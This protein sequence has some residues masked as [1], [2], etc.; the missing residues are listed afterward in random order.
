MTSPT[1]TFD[2]YLWPAGDCD[3]LLLKTPGGRWGLIDCGLSSLNPKLREQERVWA[4]VEDLK[5]FLAQHNIT[6]LAFVQL[7]HPELDHAK[8]LYQVLKDMEF[9]VFCTV[10]GALNRNSLTKLKELVEDRVAEGRTR[11]LG[12]ARGLSFWQEPEHRFELVALG[13]GQRDLTAFVVSL[14]RKL[15]GQSGGTTPVADPAKQVGPIIEDTEQ[16]A[17]P[18]SHPNES[19]KPSYN[20]LSII[21][22]AQY[23]EAR[24]LLGADALTFSWR[25]L[26]K[27]PNFAVP[28]SANQ[29]GLRA[30]VI[31]LPHHGATDGLPLELAPVFLQ[32]KAEALISS[33]G[34]GFSSP[35]SEVL[36]GFTIKGYQ[37][38]CTGRSAWCPELAVGRACTGLNLV[39]I[40]PDGR[41]TIASEKQGRLT[42]PGKCHYVTPA[43]VSVTKGQNSD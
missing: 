25:D 28:V 22:L 27:S 37:V 31:K 24:V 21:T 16:R 1:P 6:R 33:S 2:L 30:Q 7:S 4:M 8:G 13:P 42:H 14:Q 39:T 35:S 10:S 23:G 18:G 12:A 20:R 5:T 11:F 32:E 38:Y 19:I 26:A 17:R 43:Q 36:E 15:Y 3:C 40:T 9:E 41:V 34:H 29:S